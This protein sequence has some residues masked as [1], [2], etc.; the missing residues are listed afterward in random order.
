MDNA[1]IADRL[2]ALASLLELAEANPYTARAYRRAAETVRNVPTPVTELVQSGRVRD[3]RGVGPG[4]EA[5]LRELV[6]PA[7]SPSSPSSSASSPPTSSASAATSGWARERSVQIARALGVRTAD[8]LREAAAEG[9]LRTVPGI[10]PKTEAQLREALAQEPEDRPR[11]GLLLNRARELVDT[12]AAALDAEPA[13]D[14]RRWRDSCEHLA[15]VCAAPDPAPVLARFA[16]LPQIVALVEQDDGSA[17]GV[18]VEGVPVE[19]VTSAPERFG[20]ALLRATGA[21]AY[22][23]AL[24]PLPDAPDEATVYRELKI[25]WCPPELREA[26]FA[27]RA[28]RAPRARTT[29]AA[30]STATPRGRTGARASRRWAARPATAATSTSR[31]ATTRRPSAPSAGSRPTTSAARPTRSPRPTRRSPRS[32]SCAGSNATSSPTAGSTS[33]T[34]SSP[35][36]TGCRPACTAASAC[37]R[38]R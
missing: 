24:E 10:G 15:V 2:D 33:P 21:P 28:A 11:Q 20:T 18:T 3:L 22:V 5:R 12:I 16:E 35:S 31:S 27:R 38:A 17:L 26:P 37:P 32:A 36:S 4:I 23:D 25:P 1:Q 9:R 7:R 29:S 19:L 14:V 34:T 13:G 6:T 30:T 8:E